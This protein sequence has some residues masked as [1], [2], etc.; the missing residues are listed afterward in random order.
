MGSE[1]NGGSMMKSDLSNKLQ[2]CSLNSH[3][4]IPS[5]CLLCDTY[6]ETALQTVSIEKPIVSE[7]GSII[8]DL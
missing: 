1:G 3:S 6:T 5:I 7:K 8:H 4:F 2:D